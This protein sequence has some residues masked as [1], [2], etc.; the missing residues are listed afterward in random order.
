MPFYWDSFFSFRYW[1]HSLWIEVLDGIN[2]VQKNSRFTCAGRYHS[3]TVL[4]LVLNVS[5]IDDNSKRLYLYPIRRKRSE[6]YITE[7]IAAAG[8]NTQFHQEQPFREQDLLPR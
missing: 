8:V 4:Y 5:G 1:E 3:S 7:V 6:I 2:M